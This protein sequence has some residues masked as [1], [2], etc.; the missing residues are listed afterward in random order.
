MTDEIAA[1]VGLADLGWSPV[2]QQQLTL[3]ELEALTPARVFAVQRS[4]LKLVFEGGEMDVPLGGRWFQG[5]P[6]DRPTVGDWV[7]LDRASGTVVRLLERKSLLKRMSVSRPGDVQL[8][9]ANVDVLFLVSSCNEEFNL[10]RMERYLTLALEAGVQPVVVLTKADLAEDPDSFRTAAE[11]L[12][13]DL[14]VEIVNALD[15]ASLDGLRAWCGRGQTVTLLGSSG[16]GKSTLINSLAGRDI[17]ATGGIREDDA[18]GRHTTT[19]RSLHLL[20][21]GGLLLDSP[22]MRELG[23][24]DADVGLSSAFAD[25]ES[26]AALCRFNDCGHESEP[27]CAVRAAILAGELDE[28]R[29]QSY[30]KL[31]REELYNTE[32]VAERHARV[33]Q[34]SK[35]VKQHQAASH[36]QTNKKPPRKRD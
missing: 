5:S 17:Q 30:R 20:P 10:S 19:H 1:A 4:G 12:G 7:L 23:I 35:M 29:L 6:E 8:I 11:A 33:R 25:V 15:P 3:E 21:G 9:A 31:R 27:G 14:V 18:K 28:R 24:T 32:T 22:G 2:F 26:L 34:F 16:V 36:K 13:R